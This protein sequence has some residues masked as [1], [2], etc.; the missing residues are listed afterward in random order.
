MFHINDAIQNGIPLNSTWHYNHPAYTK[1][2]TDG[3]NKLSAS[4][5]GLT[6]QNVGQLRS[7]AIYHL[8]QGI[9]NTNYSTIN[10]FWL[11]ASIN[12]F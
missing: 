12:P 7:A 5:S 3:L 4:S 9:N 8:H 11:N 6:T 2:V 1:W 10:Q